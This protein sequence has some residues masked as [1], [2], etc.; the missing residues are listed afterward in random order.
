MQSLQYGCSE[1]IPYIIGPYMSAV[2]GLVEVVQIERWLVWRDGQC[3][4]L[5]RIDLVL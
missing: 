4:E 3:L 1:T 5:L 2:V